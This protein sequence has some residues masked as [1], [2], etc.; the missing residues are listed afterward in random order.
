MTCSTR[1]FPSFGNTRRTRPCL[2]LSRPVMT[3]T[4]SFLLMSIRCVS[5]FLSSLRR[6]MPRLYVK[7]VSY[8]TSGANDTIFKNFFSRSSRATGP[9]TRVP[10]GSPVSLMSTAAF[11]SKRIY[12][13]S[14]R[15]VSFAAR[16]STHFTTVPF[17][18]VPS[19]EASFTEAVK[20]SPRC[21]V[22]PTPPPSGRMTCSLR[23]PELSATSNIDLIITA[24]S[25]LPGSSGSA[26]S[27]SR[28]ARAVRRV[29]FAHPLSSTQYGYSVPSSISLR[30]LLFHALHQRGLL[31]DFFQ[32]PALQ[33]RHGTSLDDADDVA[34]AAAVLLIVRVKLL[35]ALDGSAIELVRLQHVY[36][37]HD[38]FI[39]L[40]GDDVADFDV[41]AALLGAGCGLFCLSHSLL[42]LGR[43]LLRGGFFLGSRLRSCCNG[44]R[45]RGRRLLFRFRGSGLG[46]VIDTELAF[47]R[48]GLDAGQIAAQA[49]D[50][51]QAFGLPHAQA[52]LELEQLVV[53]LVQ[54]V[55]EFGIGGVTDL[56]SV[57]D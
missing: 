47:A 20:M 18:A 53:H 26:A 13:P 19:G 34:D 38:G 4:V 14:L 57:H 8:R 1:I 28:P 43:G 50:L 49:A 10:T 24:M 52:E 31:D 22:S 6:G 32:L 25:Y 42:P 35:R 21:A 55:R 23:A 39:H 46:F 36:L 54:L 5:I 11:W 7:I 45:F 51:L 29:P 41:A 27:P 2:P 12:V 48:D 30:S 15:R 16:T 3:L 33:L 37:H 40:G 17:L 56:F 9:K 44:S